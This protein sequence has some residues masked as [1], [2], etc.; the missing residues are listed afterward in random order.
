MNISK[1]FGEVK[2]LENVNFEVY[3]GEVVGLL[4]DNG[5]GKSTLIKIIT[6]YHQ[7]D[8]GGEIYFHGKKVENLTVPKA[9]A[10]GVE[11]V[12]QEKALA[13]DQS[14]WRNIFMGREIADRFGFLD[15]KQMRAVTQ[16]LMT[17]HMGFTSKAVNPDTPVRTMSGGERQGIAITRALYFEAEL[18][19]LDEPTMALSLSETRKVL[20]FIANIPKAGKAGIFIDHNIFHVYPVVD[21]IVVLDRGRVAGEFKKADVTLEELIDRL[22]QVARTGRLEPSRGGKA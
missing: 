2:S 3:P 14:V 17:E 12:Y 18:I 13:D 21:R 6:G 4:G 1:S 15:I 8:P 7:P 19:I 22:Y 9:R 16:R 5:A 10:L 20:D 11:T